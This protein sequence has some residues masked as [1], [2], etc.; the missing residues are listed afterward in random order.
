MF[1]KSNGEMS[2]CLAHVLLLTDF[3]RDNIYHTFAFAVVVTNDLVFFSG[4]M[5][6]NFSGS[7]YVCTLVT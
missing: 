1:L 3:A 5:G 6:Y 4:G 2:A 7:F